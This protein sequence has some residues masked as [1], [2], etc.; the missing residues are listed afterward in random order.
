MTKTKGRSC[1]GKH[2]F[3]SR[4]A[5]LAYALYRMRVYG[6]TRNHTD[7]YHCDYC[8]HWHVGHRPRF[9]PTG[10]KR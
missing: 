4:R 5:A 7:V 1:D 10:K 6:A 8:R 2:Q 3:K 9:K